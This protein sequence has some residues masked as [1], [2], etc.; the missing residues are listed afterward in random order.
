MKY[1]GVATYFHGVRV[2]ARSAMGMPGSE[3]AREELACRVLGDLFENVVE[4]KLADDLYCGG[5]SQEEL[6]VN[7]KLLLD[8]L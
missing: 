4:A 2:N 1:C 5:A 6:L 3:A 8:A 7:L